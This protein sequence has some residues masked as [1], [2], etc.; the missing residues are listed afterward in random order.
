ME[1]IVG[2]PAGKQKARAKKS[3]IAGAFGRDPVKD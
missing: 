3:P 2:Q 1:R